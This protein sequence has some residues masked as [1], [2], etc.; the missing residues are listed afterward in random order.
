MHGPDL[1]NP[2]KLLLPQLY[3]TSAWRLTYIN[4]LSWLPVPS[5][6]LAYS[7]TGSW[8]SP[9]DR[10][11]AFVAGGE[12]S[13]PA[14]FLA[15]LNDV[16]RRAAAQPPSAQELGIAQSETVNSF[17]FNFSSQ[18]AQLQRILSY[19]LLGLPQV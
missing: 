1:N 13:R 10:V 2:G 14:E 11:G 18:A 16:F 3:A 17:V 7:V 12:T 5:Q 9:P 19:A 8:D 4:L 6:G 15:A